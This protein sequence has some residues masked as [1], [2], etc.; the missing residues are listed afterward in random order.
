MN[1][2]KKQR[3]L[4]LINLSTDKIIVYEER[5]FEKL[6]MVCVYDSIGSI[7]EQW[8]FPLNYKPIIKSFIISKN[9]L[10]ISREEYLKSKYTVIFDEE[11]SAHKTET[12]SIYFCSGESFSHEMNQVKTDRDYIIKEIMNFMVE[13]FTIEDNE[14][15]SCYRADYIESITLLEE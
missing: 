9:C 11:K 14:G 13:H 1:F 4:T 2:T 12:L 10:F 6:I 7:K 3:L 15:I 8:N 5:V